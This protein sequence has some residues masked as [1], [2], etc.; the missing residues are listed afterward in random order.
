MQEGK[1][2]VSCLFQNQGPT[3]PGGAIPARPVVAKIFREAS[4]L[5][6]V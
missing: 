6:L 3:S 4:L 2:A 5:W 1:P